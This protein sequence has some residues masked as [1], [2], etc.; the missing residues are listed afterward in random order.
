MLRKKLLVLLVVQLVVAGG[1]ALAN[2]RTQPEPSPLLSF[3]LAQ[4]NRLVIADPEETVVLKLQGQDWILPDFHKLPAN[5]ARVKTLLSDLSNLKTG[6][7]VATTASAFPRFE[8]EQDKFQRR[9]EFYQGEKLLGRLYVGSS[10]SFRQAHV[11]VDGDQKTYSVSLNSYDLPTSGEAWF[12]PGLL[13]AK[14][15]TVIEG[16]DYRL[17]NSGGWKLAQGEVDSNKVGQL[18][19]ALAH[20]RVTA[21]EQVTPADTKVLKVTAADGQHVYQLFE[22]GDQTYILRNDY[23]LVFGLPKAA[24]DQL[25]VDHTRLTQQK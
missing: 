3:E 13:A 17:E 10:P 23:D 11:R 9:V 20:L 16:G 21:P 5:S 18:T 6:W 19:A 25:T 12:D 8:V 14:N 24:Y 15:P 4:A 22:S 7:P 2:H 1:L